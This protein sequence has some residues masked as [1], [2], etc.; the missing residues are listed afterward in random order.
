MLCAALATLTRDGAAGFTTRKV[1]EAASTSIPAVYEFFGD[2]GGL[3]REMFFDGFRQLRLSFGEV[4]ETDDARADLVALVFAFRAFV[5]AN[6]VLSEVMFSR[7]FRDFDPRPEELGAGSAVREFVVAHVRRC[8]D[9]GVLAGDATDI[10]HVLLALVHGMASQESAGWLGT[11]KASVD[12][13]WALAIRVMLD[14][15][16]AANAHPAA[17]TNAAPAG[18]AKG[19]RAGSANGNPAKPVVPPIPKRRRAAPR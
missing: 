7:P 6:P 5:C 16:R 9:A 14:G 3:V 11:S 1:A 15:F 18:S 17:P 2:R 13:R 19:K 4:E 10:S 12:R 8:I